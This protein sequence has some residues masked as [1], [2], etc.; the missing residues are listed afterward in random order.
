MPSIPRILAVVAGAIASCGALAILCQDALKTGAWGLEHALMPVLVIV[1][2]LSGHL[3]SAA[4]RAFKP[5][6]SLGFAVVATIA[7]WGTIYTS[8]GKQSELAEAKIKAAE[9]NNAERNNLLARRARGVAMLEEERR[10]MARECDTGKG[11]RCDGK[12]VTVST[13][14]DALASMQ[15]LRDLALKCQLP[16]KPRRWPNLYPRYVTEI[17]T[18]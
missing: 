3:F 16:P 2:I 18:Q 17:A 12:K 5:L 1:T 9:S 14:E 8:V 11:T 7:T 6:S 10:A 15:N 4:V 13:Y